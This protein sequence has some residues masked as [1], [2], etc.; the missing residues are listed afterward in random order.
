MCYTVCI[1]SLECCTKWR[2]NI[3]SIINAFYFVV[4][5]SLIDFGTACLNSQLNWTCQGGYLHVQKALWETHNE[6][7]STSDYYFRDAKPNLQNKCNNK[8]TCNFTATD[9]SLNVSCASSCNGLDYIYKCIS[10]SFVLHS[11]WIIF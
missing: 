11:L 6:C 9:S 2:T 1:F 4:F 5:S 10:K 8:T 7:G 3:I